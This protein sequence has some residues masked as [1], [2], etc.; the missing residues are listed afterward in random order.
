MKRPIF[1]RER[2]VT[3]RGTLG[4]VCLSGAM[5]SWREGGMGTDIPNRCG[6]L[7]EG[8]KLNLRGKE[9]E[10]RPEVRFSSSGVYQ[11]KRCG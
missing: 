10:L 7:K 4:L 3:K 6:I 11:R 9:E 1:Y 5:A 2:T 8:G